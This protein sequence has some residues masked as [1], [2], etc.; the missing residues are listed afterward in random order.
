MNS[1]PD[2]KSVNRDDIILLSE[3]IMNSRYWQEI[4]RGESVKFKAK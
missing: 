3:I 4:V 1:K 2:N